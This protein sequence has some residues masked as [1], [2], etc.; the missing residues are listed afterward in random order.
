MCLKLTPRLTQDFSETI[1]VYFYH[2]NNQ[3]LFRYL[4]NLQ[5]FRSTDYLVPSSSGESS[6][7]PSLEIIHYPPKY[8]HF[9]NLTDEREHLH[10]LTSKVKYNGTF[11]VSEDFEDRVFAQFNYQFGDKSPIMK[12]YPTLRVRNAN[13]N[14]Q[15]I[16][17]K[18]TN[19]KKEQIF[20]WSHFYTA[21]SNENILEQYISRCRDT[22]FSRLCISTI[23][24]R[25]KP[26]DELKKCG[27][28]DDVDKFLEDTSDEKKKEYELLSNNAIGNVNF[29]EVYLCFEAFEKGEGNDDIKLCC[30]PVYYGPIINLS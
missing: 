12:L 17:C 10:F 11:I 13:E 16:R 1:S 30:P 28:I 5:F 20:L 19:S 21:Y 26:I 23:K 22:E 2:M 24:D 6:A 8:C 4:D 7:E 9:R 29:D 3:F 18:L 15:M 14:I 25:E 27:I